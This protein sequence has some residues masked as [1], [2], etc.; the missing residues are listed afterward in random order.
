MTTLS[1]GRS[2][3]VARPAAAS[4]RSLLG[5]LLVPR[6]KDLVKA[7]VVPLA[8]AVGAVA[9]G[10]VGRD[11]VL[12][13]VL[14]WV[15]LELLV[16]QARY[17]WNDV[18]GFAADQAHPEAASRGRLPGPVEKGPQHIAASVAVLGLRLV[19][20]G[21]VAL[22]LPRVEGVVLAMTVG[23]FGVAAVYER[24]RSAAT[25]RTSQVPV[26]LRPAL[27][28]L[29]V[30][31]GAG[32]AVRGLTGL[33]LAVP[34]GG[35]PGL[36]AAAAVAMWALGVVFVTCRWALEAMCFGTLHDGRVVWRARP[37]QAREHT[38]GLVRWLPTTASPDVEQTCSWR[39]LQ[40]RTPLHAPWHLALVVAAGAAALTGA[41]LVDQP[42][43]A[44]A[45]GLSL[46]GAALA[47]AVAALPGRRLAVAV[48]GAVLLV[49]L[50]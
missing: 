46:A 28:G 7:L 37:D 3:P 4:G 47:F 22:A 9:R 41:L 11:A 18:R 43:A 34:L 45:L 33:A 40:G 13:A 16:Y 17:Q 44:A 19:L 14:V 21:L 1:L 50:L 2:A 26:P 42:G 24:L 12:R 39:A 25:G 32:Y 8:F 6:P 31:V 27:L 30:A 49:G 48:V 38:L 35:R 36:V 23:V 20:A 10:G 29:W 15:V 5:Y